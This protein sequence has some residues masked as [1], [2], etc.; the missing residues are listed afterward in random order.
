[1]SSFPLNKWNNLLLIN[2][3]LLTQ[4]HTRSRTKDPDQTWTS[5]ASTNTP[6]NTA[7]PT[8]PHGPDLNLNPVSPTRPAV[9][10]RDDT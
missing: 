4:G 6:L 9:C 8:E 10:R 3:Q 1:M 5:T 7:A 2:D